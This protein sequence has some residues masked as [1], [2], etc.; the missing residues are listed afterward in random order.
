MEAK[1]S[2]LKH[3]AR[4]GNNFK[5][6]NFVIQLQVD[7]RGCY[8]AIYNQRNFLVMLKLNIDHVRFVYNLFMH[9]Y[10]HVCKVFMGAFISGMES[11]PLSMHSKR[12]KLL[13][14]LTD[15]HPDTLITQYIH[16]QYIL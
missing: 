13:C 7:I 16:Y 10:M 11:Q 3:I 12:D 8:A 14:Y 6:I 1:H 4:V 15:M 9:A 5:N 2:Y